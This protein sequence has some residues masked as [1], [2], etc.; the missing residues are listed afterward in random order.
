MHDVV[1]ARRKAA[2][3]DEADKAL[4]DA[5]L[6]GDLVVGAALS[7]R[8]DADPL[9]ATA[10][11]RKLRVA[12]DPEQEAIDRLVARSELRRLAEDW[13]VEHRAGVGEVEAVTWA[14][15]DPF[16]WA[17]EFPEV[18]A[19]GGFDAIVGNPPFQ[20]GQKITGAIGP[21]YRNHL[22][23]WLANGV[24]GSA[25]L[26][27]YF[28]LRSARLIRGQGGIGLIATNTLAQGG[29]REVGLDQLVEGGLCIHRAV[30]SEPWPGGANLEM[31]TVWAWRDGWLGTRTLDR[32]PASGITP[33]LTLRSRVSGNAHRLQTNQSQAFQGSIVLG[34]G[35]VLSPDEGHKLLA[36][37][38]RN[39]DVVRPYLVG[40]DL[41]QRPDGSPS[42]YV[43]DFG[44]RTREQAAEYEEPFDR[45]ANFVRPERLR[46]NDAAARDYWWRFLRR[47]NELYGAIAPFDR[48]IAITLVSK[49]V[50]PMVVP[51]GIVYAHR[52]G[53]FAYDDDAHFGV[54]SSGFHWWWAVTRSSTLETRVNYA[55]TDCFETFVQ[56]T[57]TESIGRLGA[58]LHDHRSA[59]MLDR[60]EGLTKIYNRVCNVDERADDI[61]LLRHIHVELDHAVRDAFGWSDLDLG[62]GFH[63][64]KFGTRFTFAPIPRQEVLDRLLE[65]NHDRYAEEVRQGL[66]SKTT[67]KG[68]AK[69]APAGAM[70]L[71]FEGV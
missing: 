70:T 54:L 28:F 69:A 47:R 40:E 68:K 50:Q 51:T 58:A 43:I 52:L 48:C 1:D 18:S 55:P 26:V 17:L 63:E 2:M 30:A 23:T 29:T 34:M 33:A 20:G 32:A 65:L 27:A 24:R 12:L 3:L 19:Q 25:D 41:N 62:H 16:H 36:A 56:P 67:G 8:D 37:D 71:G 46:Q 44:N 64:T 13:L 38:S 9:A 60:Q 66:H 6:L 21:Q 59:L 39:A 57:L 42:R 35:F 4:A 15:R 61:V 49:A 10:V 7:Q 14:E 45:V 31:A 22:V 11:A 53:V 5:R